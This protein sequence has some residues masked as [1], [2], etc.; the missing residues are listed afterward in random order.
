MVAVAMMSPG[1]GRTRKWMSRF[2]AAARGDAD[3]GG[4]A[5]DEGGDVGDHAD[6]AAGGLEGVEDGE[7]AV[8]GRGI[9][10]AEAFVDQQR[11]DAD[12]VGRH[13]G[14]AERERERDQEALAA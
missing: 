14:Q 13:R 12:V 2:A 10:G 6:L 5:L 4:D 9:E 1:L 3:V 8:E 7:R 11:A